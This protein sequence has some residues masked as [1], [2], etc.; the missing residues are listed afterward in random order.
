MTSFDSNVLLYAF[1]RRCVEH[2]RARSAV[3][4]LSRSTDVVICE[5]ATLL[6][7][8]TTRNPADQ[9]GTTSHLDPGELDALVAC[10]RCLDGRLD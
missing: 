5:L 6:E 4:E 9:H 1:D 3:E 8:L 10:L 2:E 7:V